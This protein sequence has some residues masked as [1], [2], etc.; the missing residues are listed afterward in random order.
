MKRKIAVFVVSAM[1]FG[2]M[3]F[4]M[5][6]PAGAAEACADP[7]CPWSPVTQ[8]VRDAVWWVDRTC[9][10]RVGPIFVDDPC[11]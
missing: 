1:T 11:P 6:A 10:E 3:Q 8:L 9:H 7:N 2:V 4:G 5:A